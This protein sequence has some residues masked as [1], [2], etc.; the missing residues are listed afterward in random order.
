MK[1]DGQPTAAEI[2]RKGG[3]AR[4]KKLTAERRREIARAGGKAAAAK[5]RSE[6]S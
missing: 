3:L 2:G 4:A 6:K 1:T 5:R